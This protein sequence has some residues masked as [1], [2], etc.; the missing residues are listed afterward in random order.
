LIAIE[1]HRADYPL[2]ARTPTGA[3]DGTVADVTDGVV[4]L[5]IVGTR[6]VQGPRP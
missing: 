1:S 2:A 5:A 4:A 3:A 6:P